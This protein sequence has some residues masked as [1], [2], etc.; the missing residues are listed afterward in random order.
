MKRYPNA[1]DLAATIEDARRRTSLRLA[2]AVN[3][4]ASEPSAKAVFRPPSTARL[5]TSRATLLAGGFV[6]AR[7]AYA[8]EA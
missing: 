5:A 2:P 1:Y 3:A 8:R 6:S 7:A 4:T